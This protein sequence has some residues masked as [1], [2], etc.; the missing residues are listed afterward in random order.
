MYK[1][2]RA[3][4]P[5]EMQQQAPTESADDLRRRQRT[6]M[7]R[8]RCDLSGAVVQD[9]ARTRTENSDAD[10]PLDPQRGEVL[11]GPGATHYGFLSTRQW[12]ADRTGRFPGTFSARHWRAARIRVFGWSPMLS[13][14]GCNHWRSKSRGKPMSGGRSMLLRRCRS[15]SSDSGSVSFCAP[16]T[17]RIPV[18]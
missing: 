2:R 14:F 10:G 15:A 11:V 12:G 16:S 9:V 4:A 18:G 13:M 1:K 8:Y 17:E 5:N 7:Q 3:I 6:L